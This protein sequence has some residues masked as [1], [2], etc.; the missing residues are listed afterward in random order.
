MTR[1]PFKPGHAFRDGKLYSFSEVDVEVIRPWGPGAGAWAKSTQRGIW[2]GLRPLL[3][4]ST[5]EQVCSEAIREAGTVETL[6]EAGRPVVV[7]APLPP[8]YAGRRAAAYAECLSAIPEPVRRALRPFRESNWELL[9]LAQACGSAFLDLVASTPALALAL[10]QRRRLKVPIGPSASVARLL[11]R[12]QRE[13]AGRLGFPPTESTVRILR[14]VPPPT[15]SFWRLH[16]LRTALADVELSRRLRFAPRLNAS[17]LRLLCDPAAAPLVTPSFIDEI[18]GL[19][20]EDKRPHI[21]QAVLELRELHRGLGH[22]L[23]PVLR[24]ARALERDHDVVVRDLVGTPQRESVVAVGPFPSP[25]LPETDGLT[26]IASAEELWEEGREMNHCVAGYA[27][28]V[29]SGSFYFYRLT[30][31]ERA[32]V[33]LH[34]IKDFW[35]LSDVRGPSNRDVSR[36][37]YRSIAAWHAGAAGAD[38]PACT[39]ERQDAFDFEDAPF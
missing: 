35:Y 16:H 29:A 11:R 33:A 14:R 28:R 25:P 12:R 9:R 27:S 1:R 10:A 26:A 21:A 3:S 32:T 20:S 37:T 38:T 23:P 22:P 7:S 36:E 15:L 39:D 18:A 6:D 24:S 5:M 2:R 17:V 8:T 19:R 13:I 4:I 34:W 30:S 31:P